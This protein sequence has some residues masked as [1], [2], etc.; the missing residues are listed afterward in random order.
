MASRSRWHVKRGGE[1]TDDGIEE[2]LYS[3][4][5]QGAATENGYPLIGQGSSAQCLSDY[6]WADF[7]SFKVGLQDMVVMLGQLFDK[8]MAIF[9]TAFSR[10]FRYS[11]LF[12]LCIGVAGIM[13]GL[14]LNEVDYPFK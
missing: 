14:V 6:R 13:P 11:Y 4:I 9:I 10:R 3:F 8:G 1:V 7:M 5:P 12:R 2:R